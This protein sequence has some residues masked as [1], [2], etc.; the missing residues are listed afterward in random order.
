MTF[1][2]SFGL[3]SQIHETISGIKDAPAET[4]RTDQAL[5]ELSGI[6]DQLEALTKAYTAHDSTQ[7][8]VTGTNVKEYFDK[9]EEL[10]VKCTG[11]LKALEGKVRSL[12]HDAGDNILQRGVKRT[13]AFLE[14]KELVKTRQI[15]DHNVSI[16]VQ[17]CTRIYAHYSAANWNSRSRL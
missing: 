2:H 3:T 1:F 14:N 10:V 5:L 4:K 7:S 17:S 15:I 6:L 13:R 16:S 11:D 8:N 12:C 9:V